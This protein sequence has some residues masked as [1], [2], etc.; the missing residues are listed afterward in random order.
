MRNDKSCDVL[1]L[2]SVT[3]VTKT[4]KNARS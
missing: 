1:V 4:T 3:A 2:F